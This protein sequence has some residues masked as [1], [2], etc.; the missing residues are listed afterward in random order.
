MLVDTMRG[1]ILTKAARGGKPIGDMEVRF[2]K[3]KTLTKGSSIYVVPCCL[4][5][6]PQ[7]TTKSAW[8]SMSWIKDVQADFVVTCGAS[9][10]QQGTTYMLDPFVNVFDLKNLTSMSPIGFPPLAAFVRMHPRM[11]STSIVVSQHGQIH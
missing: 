3:S 8:T 9:L 2:F 5:D 10:K 6:A 1:C 11:V 7:V 4:S